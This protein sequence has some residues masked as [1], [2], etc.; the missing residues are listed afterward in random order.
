M[1]VQ[2]DPGVIF[3]NTP[4]FIS[5]LVWVQVV[6]FNV[7]QMGD[8]ERRVARFFPE[9]R[10]NQGFANKSRGDFHSSADKTS[11][12]NSRGGTESERDRNVILCFY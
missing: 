12:S 5:G 9:F 2:A 10:S 1:C 11:H 3:C 6:G 8:A 7:V 4:S